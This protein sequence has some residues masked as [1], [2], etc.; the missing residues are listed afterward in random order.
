MFLGD[1]DE[2]DRHFN[3]MTMFEDRDFFGEIGKGGNYYCESYSSKVSYGPDGKKVEEIKAEKRL[4]RK[5]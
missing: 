3:K 4:G 2:L 1:F 5:D